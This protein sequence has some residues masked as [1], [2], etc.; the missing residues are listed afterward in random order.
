V[1]FF[2]GAHISNYWSQKGNKN[3]TTMDDKAAKWNKLNVA[4]LNDED[5]WSIEKANF[6]FSLLRGAATPALK[7]F[8][9]KKRFQHKRVNN[10]IQLSK[11]SFAIHWLLIVLFTWIM[12]FGRDHTIVYLYVLYGIK[13]ILQA[14]R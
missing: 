7:L 3:I 12:H 1:T 10:G 6:F 9:S 5:L 2:K 14:D 11:N 13:N 4:L 8:V